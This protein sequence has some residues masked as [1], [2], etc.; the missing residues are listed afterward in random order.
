MATIRCRGHPQLLEQIK[1]MVSSEMVALTPRHLAMFSWSFVKLHHVSWPFLDQVVQSSLQVLQEFHGRDLANLLWASAASVSIE[2]PQ[3]VALTKA[4]ETVARKALSDQQM[5]PQGFSN[6]LW[7]C[8]HLMIPDGSML[9]LSV[10][11]SKFATRRGSELQLRDLSNMAWSLAI[12]S[13]QLPPLLTTRV[14]H[15]LGGD[16][17]RQ[18][19]KLI[20]E[21]TSILALIWAEA[22][23]SGAV[24]SPWSVRL[25]DIGRKLDAFASPQ[26]VVPGEVLP[27]GPGEPQVVLDLPDR[28]VVLK[29]SGW[30][31]DQAEATGSSSGNKLSAYLRQVLGN[32]R[33]PILTD[34][35][36][37]HGFLHRLDLP[38]S[39]LVLT[40]KNYQA[41]YDLMV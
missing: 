2:G 36:H 24:G 23:S 32:R 9:E 16:L 1:Q 22:Y 39:G 6:V 40:A 25:Q 13:H 28:L 35:S 26:L 38:S 3:E 10:A 8:A 29:P 34:E 33:F 37:Q 21:A 19:P 41:F 31:V 17:H 15:L 7:A 18:R 5:T 30:E 4:L 27:V 11:T 12:Y 20:E 14:T